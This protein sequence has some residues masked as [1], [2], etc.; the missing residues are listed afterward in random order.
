MLAADRRL[1]ANTKL[2]AIDG[3][4]R[5]THLAREDFPALLRAGDLVIAND[6]ATIPASLFGSHE[7]TGASIEL[8]LAGRSSIRPDDV[9]SF[10]AVAFGKG[11][12][13]TRTED[14]SVPPEFLPGDTL[15]LGPL[16][17][18]IEEVVHSKLLRIALEGEPEVIWSGLATHGRPIQYRHLREP[19]SL[20]DAWTAFAA[21]PAAF[22]APSAGFALDWKILAELRTRNVGFATLTH[23]AGISSTGEPALDAMLPLD[24]PY[25]LPRETAARI[26]RAKAEGGRV[27]AVGTTVV[28]ALEHAGRNGILA[29]GEGIATN[30][31]GR[32]A[33][34]KVVDAILSGTHEAGTSH[35]ELL[36]AFASHDT[37]KVADAALNERGY[38]T[39]EF[40]DSI[41]VETDAE[42]RRCRRREILVAA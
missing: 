11:D 22:E 10:I 8:R 42:K 26:R 27:I 13:R 18:R 16:L 4:G 39:H 7:P 35:Y 29:A 38:L 3:H 28:R 33:C 12:W 37:L 32:N 24:E 25:R 31:I 17:A 23:A 36:L 6:A 40:G 1:G 14:R 30:R 5:I 20:W 41:F 2:L 21:I 15:H 34:L 9:R 19:L